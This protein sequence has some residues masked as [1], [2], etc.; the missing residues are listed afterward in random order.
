MNNKRIARIS[1]E[2]KKVVSDIIMHKL[3][4]PRISELT[5]V[6]EVEVTNDLSY[7]RIFISVLG[8][9]NSKKETIEGLESAR[10]FIRKEISNEVKLRHTPKPVFLLDESIERGIHIA[11]LIDEISDGAEDE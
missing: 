6:T 11:Q 2:V 3:K 1:E 5:T 10:G 9:E 8:D 7:A 4:D